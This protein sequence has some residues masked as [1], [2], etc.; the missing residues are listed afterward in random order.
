MSSLESMIDIQKSLNKWQ[1]TFLVGPL[2]VSPIKAVISTA[3]L[4]AG[5]VSA[6]FFG[7]FT[8]VLCNRHLGSGTIEALEHAFIGAIELLYSLGNV[9][10][11]GFLSNKLET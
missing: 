11:L 8:V 7:F 6:I 3:E 5:L 4:V 9:I 10:S 1:T 2:V